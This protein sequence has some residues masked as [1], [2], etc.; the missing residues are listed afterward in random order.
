MR[1]ALEQ[2]DAL[3]VPLFDT[4]DLAAG[5]FRGI[6]RQ[7]NALRFPLTSLSVGAVVIEPDTLRSAK[8]VSERAVEAK[9]QAKKLA[10]SSLFI[11][12]RRG[13]T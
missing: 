9:K 12:R 6:D 13:L 3:A 10:G 8:E 11:E 1:L 5:S 7:G 4:D 2:F